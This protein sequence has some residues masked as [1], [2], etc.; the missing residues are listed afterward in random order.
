MQI[1]TK[2]GHPDFLDLP[3]DQP[4][5]DWDDPRLVKMAHGISRHVVRFVRF[6]ERVYA[7]KATGVVAA[8]REYR[9][10][11]DLRD[12]HLPVV[13][14][15]G[16]VADAPDVGDAV[17]ITRYLDF[18]LPY[19]YLLGRGDVTLAD[20]LTDAGVVL[21]VR[22]HLEGVFWG[23]CSL[24]NILWR[25]DAGEMMAYLVDAETTE[26]QATISDR[27]REYDLQIAVENIAGGLFELQ[28]SGRIAED[29]DPVA[30]AERLRGR[31][32][33]L[34]SE[35]TRVDEFALDDRW[36]IE[37]RVRRINELGFDVEELSISRDGQTLSIKPV[38]IE[39][40]HHARELRRRTGLD[41]Q[42]NQARRLLS[43][44]DQHRAWLQR[45][46]Q[47]SIPRAVATARWLAEVYQPT[48]DSVP[49]DLRSHLEPAEMFHQLLEHRYLM[50]E[51]RGGEVRTSE[52]LEDY[53]AVVLS[54]TP[55]ERQLR[56][57]TGSIPLI[58][59]D[60]TAATFSSGTV[61][62]VSERTDRARRAIGLIDLTDLSDDHAPD[63]IDELCR[64][65]REHGTA[66]VCVWP[67]YVARSVELL[68]GS[69][70]RVATVVNF[71]SGDQSVGDVIAMTR[72]ALADGADDIDLVLPHRA[73]LAG[74]SARAGAMVAAVA[75]FVDRPVLLKVILESG[76]YPDIES[77]G[78]AA[79]L[80]IANGAD[81]VKTSTGKI[82]QGASLDAARAMLG[83]I[84]SVAES[85]RTV[86]LK[87]SGGIRSFDDAMAYLDL[88]D[89]MMG[90]GWA[91]P[92]TFRYGASGVL[93]ALLAEL[94][95]TPPPA[96]TSVY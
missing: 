20:R 31:Y 13:E 10:L 77:V 95:G 17:L 53:V 94:D 19:W 48:V 8:Q 64:R 80:A 18:S 85:G 63:G 70:V 59:F 87:P 82:A 68:E 49:D 37:Q 6:D 92:A 16:V 86:G 9:V 29:V 81:F 1:V 5:A 34:W 15:V 22:L 35:L 47:Q 43:D 60:P 26:R 96:P 79:H 2:Q 88:A 25:R 50:A 12:D 71:P 7:L 21:L 93:D 67:E 90:D 51:R 65:A 28:A 72:T 74:D 66:A 62:P 39:E 69:G 42:E 75:A 41:V 76:A 55:E 36:K 73:F 78:A 33:E 3:W 52:A 58:E 11:R 44:I 23:D 24:S 32:E 54:L 46:E 40:G 61:E 91:T 30:I 89:R 57:D 38:L 84:A 56:F 14:P 83:E 27:M 45:Q 4:L